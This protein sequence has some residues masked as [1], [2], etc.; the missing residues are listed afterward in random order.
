MGQIEYSPRGG[1]QVRT[2]EC[3]P[4]PAP[5]STPISQDIQRLNEAV[6]KCSKLVTILD[7]K[8]VAVCDQ[9]CVAEA[10]SCSDRPS[11]SRCGLSETLTNMAITVEET[12]GRIGSILERCQL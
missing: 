12:N 3:S 6:E 8:L 7:E 2:T 1:M 5:K 11:S 10:K 9:A 4:E